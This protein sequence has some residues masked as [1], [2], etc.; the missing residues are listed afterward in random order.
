MAM[1]ARK[2]PAIYPAAIAFNQ[3]INQTKDAPPAVIRRSATPL[4]VF[5]AAMSAMTTILVPMTHA[6]PGAA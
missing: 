3:W 4:V 6:H 2:I 5:F 1:R